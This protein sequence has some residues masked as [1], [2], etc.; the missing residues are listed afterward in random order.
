MDINF[1]QCCQTEDPS[2][3][4]ATTISGMGFLTH[5]IFL[6]IPSSNVS[7]MQHQRNIQVEVFGVVTLCGVVI[8]YQC[9]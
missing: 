9:F 3:S 7:A 1:K 6:C 5:F 8:G 2:C 4:T